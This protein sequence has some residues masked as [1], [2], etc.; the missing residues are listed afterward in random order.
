LQAWHHHL[1]HHL[2]P[3]VIVYWIHSLALL[4][5]FTFAFLFAFAFALAVINLLWLFFV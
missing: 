1:L 2:R 5:A 3:L 4:L